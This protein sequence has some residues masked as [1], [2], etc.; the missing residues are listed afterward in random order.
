[1][2]YIGIDP[3]KN[4]G[5]SVIFEDDIRKCRNAEAHVYSDEYLVD[6]CKD[7][8]EK[9]LL[10]EVAVERVNAMPGQGVTSMFNFGQNYGIIQGVLKANLIPYE[11][12]TPQRW[13]KMFGVTS[14]KN[15]SIAVCKRLFPGVNLKRTDKCTKDHDGMAESL[16]LAEYARRNMK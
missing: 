10:A 6:L 3:G 14:D 11:L 1:M 15:S 16:L 4:G 8:R 9:S 7:I 5:I 13:K 2:L 12:V